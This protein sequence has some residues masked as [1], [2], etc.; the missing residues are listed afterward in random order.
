LL[1]IN[2]E[3][4]SNCE[5][6]EDLALPIVS[7]AEQTHV[8]FVEALVSIERVND[9]GDPHHTVEAESGRKAHFSYGKKDCSL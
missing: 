4:L 7:N 5:A 8:E 6:L 2:C 3:E 9:S 1:L